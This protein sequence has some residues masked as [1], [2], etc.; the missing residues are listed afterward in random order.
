MSDE[1]YVRLA[2]AGITNMAVPAGKPFLKPWIER[3]FATMGKKFLQQFTGRTFGNVVL[4]GE[5]D[6]AKRAT[7]TLDEFLAWL[8]RWIV[9]VHHTTKVGTQ[10]RTA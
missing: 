8:V 4:K 6:P 2:A 9:D 1:I 10:V 7:L 5:N 3:F